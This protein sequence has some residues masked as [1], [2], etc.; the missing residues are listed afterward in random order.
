M[1]QEKLISNARAYCSLTSIEL[2][3]NAVLGHGTDGSVWET[4]A[5][6]AL[7]S[8]YRVENYEDEIEC[9]RRLK[10]QEILKINGVSV[11]HLEGSNDH[12][13]VIEMTYVQPPYILDF[14]KV[15]IDR[16]PPYQNDEHVIAGHHEKIQNEFGKDAARVHLLMHELKKLGIHYADPRPANIRFEEASQ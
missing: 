7:K 2:L 9:Y 14:G 16:P 13:M 6:T 5:K 10:S 11:P 4:S 1:D 8:F 3:E 15:Y 12:L